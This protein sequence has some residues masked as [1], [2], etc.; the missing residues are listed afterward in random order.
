MAAISYDAPGVLKEFALRKGVSYPL[1]SDPGSKTIRA[2]GILNDQ[3]K[4]GQFGF[5]VPYPV[6]FLLTRDGKVQEKFYE[7]DYRERYTASDLLVTRFGVNGKMAGEA[8]SKYLKLRYSSGTARAR[9]GQHA[10]LAVS[11]DLKPKMH[12][13]APGAT[14]YLPIELKFKDSPAVQVLKAEYPK[15]KIL[16]LKA[17]QE[18]VPVFENSFRVI[19][20]L[21]F[22]NFNQLK[23]ASPDGKLVVEAEFKYQACDDRVCYLPQTVPLRWEFPIEEFDRQRASEAAR[24]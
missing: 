7:P 4:E 16:Y 10:A 22:G 14:G 12:V 15:P 9:G 13:Y 11:I 3:I 20:E 1:L 21:K 8:E 5:G 2:F 17:I 19:Q 23:A 24:K 6:S 18:K